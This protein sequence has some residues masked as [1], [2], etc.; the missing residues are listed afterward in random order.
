MKAAFVCPEMEI[1]GIQ[2]LSRA[3]LC[4]KATK[5]DMAGPYSEKAP[6][7]NGV[8]LKWRFESLEIDCI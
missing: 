4:K 8:P 7:P 5:Q 2:H 1:F 3:S 6:F